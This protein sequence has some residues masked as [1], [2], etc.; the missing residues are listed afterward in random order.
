[1]PT[2]EGS[3]AP[4]MPTRSGLEERMLV[5]WL[6]ACD[7]V[8]LGILGRDDLEL[9]VL[10]DVVLEPADAADFG[11]D[12]RDVGFDGDLAGVGAGGGLDPGDHLLG[13]GFS[14]G[15]VVGR[16]EGIVVG[17]RGPRAWSR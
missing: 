7:L 6:R 11:T 13:A 14:G 12:A 5:T 1:M 15:L 10:G 17:W 8:G 16:E 9:G 2:A 4:K 3:F